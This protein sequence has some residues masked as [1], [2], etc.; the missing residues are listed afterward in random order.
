MTDLS[1][2]ECIPLF[3]SQSTI[4]TEVNN[5][6]TWRFVR[7]IYQEKTAPCSQACPAGQDI[8]RIEMLAKWGMFQEAW[9]TILRENPLP[10]VCGRVCFHPCERACNRK[11]FDEAVA[12]HCLER[13]IGDKAIA[14]NYPIPEKTA[15][16]N[17]KQIAIAGSDPAGL[18]AA[19]F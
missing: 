7:P 1:L 9:Q 12:V 2:N 13:F 6:G 10:A 5:T 4:S 3:I 19:W 11:D 17:G 18:S 8:P 15:Q 14:E 16:D